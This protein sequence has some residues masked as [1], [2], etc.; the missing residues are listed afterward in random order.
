MKYIVY[1]Y[2]LYPN[3]I[4]HIHALGRIHVNDKETSTTYVKLAYKNETFK[5]EIAIVINGRVVMFAYNEKELIDELSHCLDAQEVVSITFSNS[6][7]SEFTL[8]TSSGTVRVGHAEE[9][10]RDIEANGLCRDN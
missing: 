10:I 2:G 4:G 7:D 9:I 8:R 3:D 1:E 6:H 5:T